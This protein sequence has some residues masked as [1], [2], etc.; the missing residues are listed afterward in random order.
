MT[1]LF[2]KYTC[3]FILSILSACI[4]AVSSDARES[5]MQP[6]QES[7]MQP[8]QESMMQPYQESIMQPYQE[9][10]MQ[11]YIEGGEWTA[12]VPWQPDMISGAQVQLGN[13][14][15]EEAEAEEITSSDACHIHT[16]IIFDNSFSISPQNR[17][18]MKKVVRE[19]IS[20][21]RD[22]EKYT[23]ATFDHELHLLA[24]YSDDYEYLDGLAQ[25][26]EFADQLT[27][28]KDALHDAAVYYSGADADYKRFVVLS[29]GSD[30]NQVGYTYDEIREIFAGNHYPVYCVGSRYEADIGALEKMFALSRAT[31]ASYFLLD[32]M[33]DTA[34]VS[35]QIYH[36]APAGV[37]RAEIPYEAQDGTVKGIKLTV[38]VSG[39]EYELSARGQMPFARIPEMEEESETAEPESWSAVWE[40]GKDPEENEPGTGSAVWEAQSGPAAADPGNEAG[41]WEAQTGYTASE[42]GREPEAWETQTDY[43]AAE[44]GRAP[45]SSE[46]ETESSAAGPEA[47]PGPEKTPLSFFEDDSLVHGVKNIFI[48]ALAAAISIMA[49]TALFRKKKKNV[50][51]QG[52]AENLQN[53]QNEDPLGFREDDSTVLLKNYPD[54]QVTKWKK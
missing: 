15:E 32:D 54:P 17:E 41:A 33:T 19:I 16:I 27:F 9:F 50:T 26:I 35:D 40:P 42:A 36:D 1:D 49:G 53:I 34:P 30:D 12:Y 11:S 6:Y 14:V 13:T 29:D 23:L 2:K 48:L 52:D 22:G 51:E 43:I 21:H 44:A 3:A 31:G 7:V 8:Y 10:M 5:V 24:G 38:Q 47:E 45:E 18:I 25:K 4:F 28:L 46:P 39:S 20:L 37:I